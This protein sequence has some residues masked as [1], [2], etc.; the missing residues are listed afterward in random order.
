VPEVPLGPPAAE[1]GDVGQAAPRPPWFRDLGKRFPTLDGWLFPVVAGACVLYAA[2]A[3]YGAMFAETHGKWSAP[4]DDVFIHFDYARAT[5][6]G[7]PFQWTEGNGF[8]SG[9]TSV[10]YP[11]IL[12]LGYW[13]FARGMDL[14]VWAAV[15]AC[16][17]TLVFLWTSGEL[18][19]P[20][21]RWAK[22]LAPPFVLAL[23]ALDWTLFSGME[24]AFHLATWGV[25]LSAALWAAR[26]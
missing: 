25:T 21:G 3:F 2:T 1:P 20:L 13:A 16:V 10:T 5:A 11:F 18:F 22:Y 6:R 12:A 14:L 9:N 7:Y 15:V 8:S 23:G 26:A 4:L 19:E 17:S 24:N